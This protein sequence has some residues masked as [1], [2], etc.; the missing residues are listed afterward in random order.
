MTSGFS[1]EFREN[2]LK[3]IPLRRIGTPDDVANTVAFLASEEASYITG[4]VLSVNGG[5]LMG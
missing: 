4:H 2:A 1:D 5:M 3:N